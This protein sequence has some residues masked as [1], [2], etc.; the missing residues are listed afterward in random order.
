GELPDDV[1]SLTLSGSNGNGVVECKTETVSPEEERVLEGTLTM[2]DGQKFDLFPEGAPE[3]TE[4]G[5]V[6][7]EADPAPTE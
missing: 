1:Y 4:P 7:L 5:D 6:N 3:V 2:S